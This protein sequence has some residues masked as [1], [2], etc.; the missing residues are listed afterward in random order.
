MSLE[1][2]KKKRD[3]SKT[4]EPSQPRKKKESN[5]LVY[6]IQ[7]HQ[8]SHL[9]FDLRL[10]EEGV[11][12]SWAIPKA[13][14]QETGVRR[15]A[16]QTE[17]HPLGYEDFEGVIP[18]GEYGAGKVETWDRGHYLSLEETPAKKVVEIIGKKLRGRYALIKLKVKDPEDKNW[19]FFKLQ[20]S[21]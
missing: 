21:N 6:V 8:A 10:E 12:K 1:E 17:D 16:V 19:L 5:D 4:R 7:R 18:E 20:E 3:F 9:H 14:P 2:Y 13:P 15:L 11:L